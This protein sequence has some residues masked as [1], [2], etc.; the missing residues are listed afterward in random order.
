[1]HVVF[2]KPESIKSL[3]ESIS[4]D[5]TLQYR[6]IFSGCCFYVNGSTAP[7]VSDLKLKQLLAERGGKIAISLGRRSVTHV[8]LGAP[9]AHS[10]SGG[11][12]AASK[13]QKEIARVRGKGVKFVGVEW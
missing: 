11:G 3:S 9:T 1:M 13:I 4:N 12:L 2:I 5:S 6:Q 8:I 7:L 10:G